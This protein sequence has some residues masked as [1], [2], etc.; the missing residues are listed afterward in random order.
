MDHSPKVSEPSNILIKP[1]N[2]LWA[3]REIDGQ[4]EEKIGQTVGRMES[5]M[6]GRTDRHLAK[7]LYSV[8]YSAIF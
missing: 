1:P 3:D 7:V 6:E 2:L 8:I 5:W 4:T